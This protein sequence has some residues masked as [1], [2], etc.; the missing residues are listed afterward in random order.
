VTEPGPFDGPELY[1][2]G[3]T[4]RPR[5]RLAWI[6]GLLVIVMLVAV[7]VVV[8]LQHRDAHPSAGPGGAATPSATPTTATASP[9]TTDPD[10]LR[11]EALEQLLSQ[12]TAAVTGK[13][14][15]DWLATVDPRQ[16]VFRSRQ[17]AVFANLVKLPLSRW[18][19]TVVGPGKALSAARQAALGPEAWVAEVDLGYRFGAADRTD[20]HSIESLTLVQDDGSWRVAGD[21][22]GDTDT[23]IWDLGP[24]DVV[25]GKSSVV[26]GLGSATSLKPYAAQADAAVGRVSGIW[27]TRWPRQVVVLVPKSQAQM[28]RLLG[29]TSASLSQIAAVTTGEL[30]AVVGAPAGGADQIIINPAGFAQLGS[31]GRRVVITHETTHVAV[32]ASTPRQVS[33]WLSEGFADYIGYSSLGLPRTEVAADVLGLVRRGIGPQHLPDATDFDATKSTIGPSYSASWLACEL[34]S[35]RYGPAKLIALYR[36]AAGATPAARVS[37]QQSPDAATSAAFKAV[38]GVSEAAFTKTWLSYLRQLS[39]D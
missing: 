28:G 6:A 29:R 21:S 22:D 10:V 26:I 1:H 20:V 30:T 38:L 19:Y 35:D 9:T 8:V 7:S 13:D 11:T 33:I 18:R 31:L 34:I 37:A 36:A 12:R 2:D 39:S 16:P 4:T 25:H 14:A 3:A 27:G 23:E 5:H 24:L 32:R 15:A 17:A